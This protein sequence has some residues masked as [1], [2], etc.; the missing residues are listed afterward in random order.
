MPQRKSAPAATQEVG[1][2]SMILESVQLSGIWKAFRG[3]VQRNGKPSD[4]PCISNDPLT[5][6]LALSHYPLTPDH[7]AFSGLG[8]ESV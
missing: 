3:R 5:Q 7:L 1:D 4:K 8:A 2:E 6:N